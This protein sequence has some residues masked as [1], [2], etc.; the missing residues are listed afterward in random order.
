M[1]IFG[2]TQLGVANPQPTE[3]SLI[4]D[5]SNTLTTSAYVGLRGTSWAVSVGVPDTI[6]NGTMN[7]HLA[8][9]RDNHGA[10]VYSNHS[11]DMTE[12]PAIEYNASWRFL[13]AGFVDNPYGN[14]E[15]YMFA[16]TKLAF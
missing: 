6:V 10:I 14:N 1:E 2:R 11:I 4:S 9:G 12:T 16:K 7:L 8:D 13:T 3:D 15:F 5:F